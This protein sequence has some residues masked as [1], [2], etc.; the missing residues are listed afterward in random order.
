MPPVASALSAP[1]T[2]VIDSA[3]TPEEVAAI[4]A[5]AL[6]DGSVLNLEDE[7]GRRV[8]IPVEKL[9]AG[10]GAKPAAG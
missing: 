5:A 6:K 1:T 3:Q 8:I 2:L 10:E 7:K 9:V 4:V